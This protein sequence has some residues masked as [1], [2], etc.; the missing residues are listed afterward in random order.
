MSEI[1]LIISG[2]ILFAGSLLYGL[3]RSGPQQTLGG[4]MVVAGL[5]AALT[6]GLFWSI[7]L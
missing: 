2:A 4:V 3:A 1:I 7:G 6:G 5:I